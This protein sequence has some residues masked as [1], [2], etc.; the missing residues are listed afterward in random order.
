MEHLRVEPKLPT[1]AAPGAE[2]AEIDSAL[3]RQHELFRR[4]D[5][6]S[7]RQGALVTHGQTEA[8][9]EVLGERQRVI[10]GIAETNAFLEPY[11]AR[12]DA[13]MS[14]MPEAV[15][16]RMRLRLDAMAL[17]ADTIA[18][19]D[20]ADRAELERRRNAVAGELAAISRGRG[21]VTAYSAKPG[22]PG[23]KFR[24]QEA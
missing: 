24:D 1:G 21:A 17:L 4:L 23:P 10:D 19:R 11:R 16:T 14:G 13:V 3:E 9:L 18:R 6:L 7:Q 22:S 12:W 5:G 8:L 20:E 2:T 15:R